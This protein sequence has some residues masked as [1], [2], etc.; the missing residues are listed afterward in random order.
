M[1]ARERERRIEWQ[2]SSLTR[3]QDPRE[4]ERE[5]ETASVYKK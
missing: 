4:R 1:T 3:A 5:R 2:V